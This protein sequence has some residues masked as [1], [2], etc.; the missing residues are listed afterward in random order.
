VSIIHQRS[1]SRLKEVR[2]RDEQ[3]EVFTRQGRIA[4]ADLRA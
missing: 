4:C 3:G 2:S 1:H